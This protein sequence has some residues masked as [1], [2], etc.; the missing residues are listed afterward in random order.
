MVTMS[1]LPPLKLPAAYKNPL[2]VGDSVS[3]GKPSCPE[4][5]PPRDGLRP[6]LNQLDAA[7][8]DEVRSDLLAVVDRVFEPAHISIWVRGPN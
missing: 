7:D 1:A 8:L 4:P 5:E 3:S 2:F 6:Q